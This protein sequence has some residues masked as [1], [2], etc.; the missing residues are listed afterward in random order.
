MVTRADDPPDAPSNRMVAAW[1][2][3]V[4]YGKQGFATLSFDGATGVMQDPGD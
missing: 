3:W 2:D 4:A 1:L